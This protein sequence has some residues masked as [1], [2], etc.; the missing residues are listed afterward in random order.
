[1]PLKV[2]FELSD[3]DLAYFRD[4][5]KSARKRARGK[6]GREIVAAARRLAQQ[7]SRRELPEFVKSRLETLDTMIR[8]LD[9]AEWRIEGEHRTRVLEALAYFAEPADLIPDQTPGVGFLDD[10]IMVE[11]VVQELRP[12]LDAYAEFCRYREQQRARG[13]GSDAAAK[14]R[15]E[16]RR[17]EMF[18]R[19][20]RRRA[21]RLRQGGSLFSMSDQA[22]KIPRR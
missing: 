13:R 18:A 11:L 20:N 4:A 22:I 6:D 8:M 21:R 12:E 7:T 3:A 5:M 19:I 16:A 1:M 14:E 10:A 2:A 9:D 15:L 17:R